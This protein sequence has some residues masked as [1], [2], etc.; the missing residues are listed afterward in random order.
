MNTKNVNKLVIIPLVFILVL[1]L[2]ITYAL[3]AK[4]VNTNNRNITLSSIN[5]YIGIYGPNKNNIE[6]NKDYTF[7]IENRGTI[8][9]GY[10]L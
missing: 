2:S 5:K 10:E 6:L 3:F 7:T 1:T 8:D 9:A 4:N